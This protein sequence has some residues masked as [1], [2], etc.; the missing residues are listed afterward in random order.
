MPA[1]AEVS[2]IIT[3]Y[4]MPW[5][6]QRVLQSVARQTA[7]DRM[8]IIVTDDGSTDRTRQV[9]DD[10]ARRVD[11]PVEFV[12]HEHN[13]FHL[14]RCR[15]DG[16]RVASAPYLLFLDGD[17]LLPPDHIEQYLRAR[18]EGVVHFGY[19]CRLSR[20]LS[21]QIDGEAIASGSFVAATPRSELRK[22][23]KLHYKSLFY[24]WIGHQTKPA[25]KGGNI[26]M[27]R[28]DF[29]R[30]NGFDENFREWGCEDDDLSHRARA[31]GLRIASILGRTRTYHL[32]H[33]PASSK[34]SQKW[35]E[36]PNVAYLHRPGRLTRCLNG[37]EKRS[38][39]DVRVAITAERS[40]FRLAR[41]Y[42]EEVFGAV[43]SDQPEV[44]ILFRPRRIVKKDRAIDCRIVADDGEL[45]DSIRRQAD[46]VLPLDP[47]RARHLLGKAWFLSSVSHHL[48]RQAA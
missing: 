4:Q 42:V 8:E 12:T 10:F 36:G 11:R 27:W 16:A 17:C 45:P 25:L 37:I 38:L 30:L 40:D 13:G 35:S 34:P 31:A 26:G 15:N 43:S 41:Q 46:L 48:R 44:E 23:A 14:T 20:E 3:T 39:A 24:Q 28:A 2:L 7:L 22:L 18:R 29:E 5:H 6:L 33:P 1:A 21:D 32:W 9:V 19:C 47:A